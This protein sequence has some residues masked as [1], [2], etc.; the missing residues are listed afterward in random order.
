MDSRVC[1]RYNTTASVGVTTA[2]AIQIRIMEACTSKTWTRVITINNDTR[3]DSALRAIILTRL[4]KETAWSPRTIAVKILKK[5]V[6]VCNFWKN[7][8]RRGT[9]KWTKQWRRTIR[10]TSQKAL[11]TARATINQTTTS[12][13]L[14]CQNHLERRINGPTLMLMP[15]VNSRM[16]GETKIIEKCSNRMQAKA[17]ISMKETQLKM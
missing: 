10:G 13:L 5:R 16:K 9:N 3:E 17:R 2:A 12:S 11:V 8:C 15:I 14:T 7:G 6:V 4:R 1:I